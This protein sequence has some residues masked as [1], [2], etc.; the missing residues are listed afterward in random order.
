MW[1]SFLFSMTENSLQCVFWEDMTSGLNLTHSVIIITHHPCAS[2]QQPQSAR[3][4]PS[5]VQCKPQWS[6]HCFS[7]EKRKGG[8][9][10]CGS[11]SL[12]TGGLDPEKFTPGIPDT[13]RTGSVDAAPQRCP[14]SIVAERGGET[15]P[16]RA[17]HTGARASTA[18]KTGSKT[19]QRKPRP[20][21]Q[22]DDSERGRS[23]N[24][25]EA[26]ER[27]HWACA[28]SLPETSALV[29]CCYFMLKWHILKWKIISCDQDWNDSHHL[30]HKC[31]NPLVWNIFFAPIQMYFCIVHPYN[32]VTVDV[33]V[34]WLCWKCMYV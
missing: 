2:E 15:E 16:S 30:S 26:L 10:N 8:K 3:W 4:Y 19:Q 13:V 14:P 23:L 1:W 6:S 32:S 5:V 9:K 20:R 34:L 7:N 21:I 17:Q 33:F 24:I 29:L 28:E 22:S 25:H 27:N 11:W 18:S 31:C 12:K